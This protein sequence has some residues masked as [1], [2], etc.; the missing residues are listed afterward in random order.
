MNVLRKDALGV[1]FD[2][3]LVE[4]DM[5]GAKQVVNLSPVATKDFYFTKPDG[6]IVGPEAGSFISNGADGWLRFV[7][8]AGHVELDQS[9]HWTMEILVV[10]SAGFSGTSF[11]EDFLVE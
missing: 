6:T 7:N 4:I 5:N 1:K 2:V 10:F 9:G 8:S 11:K 3:R